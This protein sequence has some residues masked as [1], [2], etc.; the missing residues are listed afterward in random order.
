MG[1][2]HHENVLLRINMIRKEK[3][4]ITSELMFLAQKFQNKLFI[5]KNKERLQEETKHRMKN[6][7]IK[8]LKR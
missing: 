2:K 3:S 4:Q 6:E 8:G 1:K 7:K 5:W